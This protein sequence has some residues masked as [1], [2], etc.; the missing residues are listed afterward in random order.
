VATQSGALNFG[1][2]GSITK[3]ATYVLAWAD[4]E[5]ARLWVEAVAPRPLPARDTHAI[6][7][8]YTGW[9]FK[10]GLDSADRMLKFG[11]AEQAEP[12]TP[13][14]EFE[15][16]EARPVFW[17]VAAGGARERYILH[18]KARRHRVGTLEVS[19]GLIPDFPKD[20]GG[21]P[22]VSGGRVPQ[23]PKMR[24]DLSS[25]KD[26]QVEQKVDVRSL[27]AEA[28][29]E[30]RPLENDLPSTAPVSDDGNR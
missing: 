26:E 27:A 22:R 15:F 8:A 4:A 17:Q 10:W 19:A 18:L 1:H 21:G 3:R 9:S 30:A 20:R 29:R 28:T 25:A 5:E 12:Q 13:F 16:W 7:V 24:L 6:H 14:D 2:S 23:L 11:A